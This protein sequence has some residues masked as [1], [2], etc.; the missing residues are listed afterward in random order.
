MLAVNISENST[1]KVPKEYLPPIRD[2]LDSNQHLPIHL[3]QDILSFDDYTV[4]EFRVDDFAIKIIPRN[5]AYNLS[6]FFKM[7][8]F[9]D[10]PELPEIEGIGF[11]NQQSDFGIQELSRSFCL[12]LQQLFQ[13]G[14][15]GEYRTSTDV[16]KFIHGE[17]DF[18]EYSPKLIPLNGISSTNIDYGLD[19]KANQIIK[20][21]L[22]KLTLV[23][24]FADNPEKYQFL[25]ELEFVNEVD[26]DESE[27]I[28]VISC[29]F[30]A[31]PFYKL[32]LEMAKKI[33]F[34]MKLEFTDGQVSWLAFLENSNDIFEKYASKILEVNLT[35]NVKKWDVPHPF[36]ELELDSYSATKS[37]SPDIIIDYN[38]VNQSCRAILDVKNKT[39]DIKSGSSIGDLVS[40]S[41][42]YQML[43]YCRKLK[44]KFGGLVYPSNKRINPV[45]VNFQFDDLNLHLISIDMSLKMQSRHIEFIK[46][47][48]Q[49]I[50]FST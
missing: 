32:A 12:L 5:P 37:F 41:D 31:N 14:L 2:L 15:T 9:I 25:R 26:L 35:E 40:T 38:E 29:F 7:L 42:L 23:E 34:N 43:F 19:I 18:S 44:T 8:Q 3:S 45:K 50:F 47:V 22:L 36:A 4:G 28:D 1:Y 30:S 20:V 33:I 10:N 46:D 13:F 24:N 21:A 39:F 49:S 11:E 27:L 48:K 17:I 6:H 16:N